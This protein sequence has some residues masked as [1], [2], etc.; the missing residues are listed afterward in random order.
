LWID[1]DCDDLCVWY[2]FRKQF[3]ALRV[4]LAR[5]NADPGQVAAG[6]GHA[7]NQAGSDGIGTSLEHNRDRRD[8]ILGRERC[9]HA[10]VR[11]DHVD[12]AADEFGGECR[13]PI[14]AVLRPSVFNT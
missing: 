9:N 11:C 2:Q 14:D 1:Q 5:Q 3:E 7:G 4:Q 12:V 13:Q 10:A 8:G 6:T